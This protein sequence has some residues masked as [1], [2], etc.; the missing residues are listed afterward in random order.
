[1]NKPGL[2]VLAFLGFSINM[3]ME[4]DYKNNISFNEIYESLENGIILEILD[5][6]I[7]NFFDFSLYPKDEEQSIFLNEVLYYIANG[8]KGRERRKLGVKESGLHLL[9]AYIFEAM[10]QKYWIDPEKS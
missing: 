6:K 7:P 2:S 8:L 5:N 3:A 9:Q 4:S 1:M 10:Q